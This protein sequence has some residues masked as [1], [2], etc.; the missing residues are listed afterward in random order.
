MLRR[1]VSIQSLYPQESRTILE[2]QRLRRPVSPHAT[3]YRP[4]ITSVLSISSRIAGC[5]ISG[6]LYAFF[7]AYAAAPFL[8]W[9]LSSESVAATVAAWPALLTA[10]A[11]GLIGFTF[12]FHSFNGALRHLVWDTGRGMTNIAVIRSGWAVVG[13]SACSAAFFALC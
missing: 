13:L 11:K 5:T 1:S 8:G 7:V 9:D 4:Q 10:S 3:I 12:F 2:K 6:G